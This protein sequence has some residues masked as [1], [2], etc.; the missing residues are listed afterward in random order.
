MRVVE[1][2]AGKSFNAV[3]TEFF[4]HG[5]IKPDGRN[6]IVA[7]KDQLVPCKVLQLGPGNFCRLAFQTVKGQMEYDILYGGDPP[8][9][10]PPPW[11]CKDG[12]LLETRHFA[13]CNLQNLEPLRRAYESSAP[14]VSD[15]VDGVFH[16]SNPFS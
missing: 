13:R 8:T 14:F 9:E 5:E 6:V 4:H 10:S 2:G 12:L 15:Y 7:A 3:V 11:T 1:L 16:G